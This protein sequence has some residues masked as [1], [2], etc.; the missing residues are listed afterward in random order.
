M[1]AIAMPNIASDRLGKVIAPVPADGAVVELA[2][3]AVLDPVAD[4]AGT[5]EAEEEPDLLVAEV[6]AEEPSAAVPGSSGDEGEAEEV[7]EDPEVDDEDVEDGVSLET[8]DEVVGEADEVG[9]EIAEALAPK[10]DTWLV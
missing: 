6:V 4:V 5:A 3:A 10:P 9:A 7:S 1:K 8:C 2:L